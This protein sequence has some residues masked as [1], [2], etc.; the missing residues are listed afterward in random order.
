M[1]DCALAAPGE[2]VCGLV[3]GR[4]GTPVRFYP[5]ANRAADRST[6]FLMDPEQQIDAMR[7]MR[8]AQLDLLGIFH[9]HPDAPAQPSGV[10]REMAAYPGVIY[11]IASMQN[12]APQLRAYL[13]DDGGF[14]ELL[15]HET[16]NDF[17]KT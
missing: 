4:S 16:P 11:F 10:D 3:G 5:I 17:E 13:Y 2:E 14:R 1:L 15:L 7:D 6:R 12:K 8:K 9:S